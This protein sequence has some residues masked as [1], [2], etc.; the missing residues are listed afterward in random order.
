[1]T[2]GGDDT[3]AVVDGEIIEA[4]G[5]Y[6]APARPTGRVMTTYQWQTGQP[7]ISQPFPGLAAEHLAVGKLCALCELPLRIGQRTRLFVTG[8]FDESDTAAMR[9]GRRFT[10]AAEVIHDHC[11]ELAVALMLTEDSP[12][13]EART[14][15]SPPPDEPRPPDGTDQ[16]DF[17]AMLRYAGLGA[18]TAAIAAAG[19]PRATAADITNAAVRAAF[20]LALANGLITLV[21][22]DQWPPYISLNP[23]YSRWKPGG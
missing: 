7:R 4:R 10:A 6:V 3:P 15:E 21:P 14:A 2:G 23:P 16:D 17:A 9:E 22:R 18:H 8:A 1:M 20:E 12:R 19:D 5:V 11:D 13:E